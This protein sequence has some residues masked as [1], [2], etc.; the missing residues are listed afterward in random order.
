[1]NQFWFTAF[2]ISPC[3]RKKLP[4]AGSVDQYPINLFFRICSMNEMLQ[5][6]LSH[7]WSITEKLTAVMLRKA[8]V[9]KRICDRRRAQ[10]AI[11][12]YRNKYSILWILDLNRCWRSPLNI[13]VISFINIPYFCLE[14]RFPGERSQPLF[15]CM[16]SSQGNTFFE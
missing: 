7:R 2:S 12:A 5:V 16:H 9:L 15:Q 1:M 14:R 3:V 8:A 4:V 6:L 11:R 13:Q 10:N